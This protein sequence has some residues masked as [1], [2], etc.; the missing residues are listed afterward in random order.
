[1]SSIS[2]GNFNAIPLNTGSG[3]SRFNN[4][5]S[6]SKE[7][8]GIPRQAEAQEGDTF[9]PMATPADKS[10]FPVASTAIGAGSGLVIGGAGSAFLEKDKPT[11]LK[12]KEGVKDVIITGDVVKH[13]DYTYTMEKADGKYKVKDI[14]VDIEGTNWGYSKVANNDFLTLGFKPTGKSAPLEKAIAN[15]L[16]VRVGEEGADTFNVH[17]TKNTVHVVGKNS[18]KDE[19]RFKFETDATGKMTLKESDHLLELI[20]DSKKP[21]I[22]QPHVDELKKLLI[23]DKIDVIKVNEKLATLKAPEA[24]ENLIH[25]A[26]RKWGVIAAIT[27]GTVAAGAGIGYLLG[28]D[29]KTQPQPPVMG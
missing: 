17:T 7:P 8:A 29:K 2:S 18:S 24:I 25:G 16:D 3:V 20:K 15:L 13:G 6:S 12:V 1:M 21:H 4:N 28:K 11:E 5:P 10:V 19:I 23:S 26:G 14:V 9:T 27:A 22:S